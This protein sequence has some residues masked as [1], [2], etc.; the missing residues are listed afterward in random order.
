M[1]LHLLL[2]SLLLTAAVEAQVPAYVPGTGLVA[3]Y[4]LNNSPNDLSGS[5]NHAVLNGGVTAIADRNGTANSAYSFNGTNGNL[6]VQSPGFQFSATGTFTYSIWIRRT[7]TAGVPLIMATTAAGNFISMIGGT[8]DMRFGTNKQ[9]SSWIWATTTYTLN[10]WEHFAAVYN[11]GSMNFYKNGQLAAS[12]TYTH[13]NATTATLPL[14]IGSGIG[15]QFFQ[16]GLDDLGIWTRALS[17]SE[18]EQLFQGCVAGITRQP[19]DTTL[20]RGANLSMI[21]TAGAS[22]VSYQWQRNSGSGFQNINNGGMFGGANSDTLRI[23]AAD[24]SLHTNQFRCITAATGCADT[25]DVATLG[26]RCNQQLSNQPLNTTRDMNTTATF[27]TS[28][29]DPATQ[30]Q[31]QVDSTGSFVNLTN[32]GQF[33]GV[34][35]DSLRINNLRTTQS[36][37]RFRCILTH[38]PCNDTTL[39]AT[40]N[41][42]NTTSVEDLQLRKLKAYPNPSAEN[43]KI[44]SELLLA[45]K[46]YRLLDQNGR[47]VKTGIVPENDWLIE[48]SS[49]AKGIYLLEVA[50]RPTGLKLVRQ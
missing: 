23:T 49:L 2:F 6:L 18:I 42:I 12:A 11:N 5:G 24:F 50:D 15:T 45:G 31:W 4:G 19:N 8:T 22:G 28:S 36:G 39:S 17:A 16:G 40:L 38:S 44:E 25:S 7:S 46:S 13:T 26:I 43:W 20:T 9:Q 47:M 41:V 37:Q 29:L 1:K 21:A 35:S 48:A 30:F 32:G 10:Q 33:S 14:Y 34:N 3:W 27:I